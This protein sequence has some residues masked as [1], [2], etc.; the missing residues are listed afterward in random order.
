[1]DAELLVTGDEIVRGDVTDT[2]SGW[3]ASRLEQRGMRVRR[4]VAVGDRNDDIERTLLEAA[5]RAAVVVVGGGLGPTSDDLTAECAARV[6]GVGFEIHEPTLVRLRERWAVRGRPMPLQAERMARIPLGATVL[7]NDEGTAPGFRLTLGSATVFFF[8]GVPREFRHLAERHLLPFV[9]TVARP[10]PPLVRLRCVGIAESEVDVLLAPIADECGVRLGLRAAFPEVHATL[11]GAGRLDE[12]AR[13]ARES[14]GVRRYGEG[15]E[16]LA[17]VVGRAL[18][19]SQ[20]TVFLA[21]SCTGGLLG[22]ELTAVPGSSGYVLGGAVVYSNDE[23][24]R[25]L[26]VDRALIEAHGAVSEEV[27]RA[28]AE[29]AR[30]VSHATWGLSITGVAGPGGGT[31][32]KPVGTVWIALAGPDGTRAELL[33]SFRHDRD[34]IR[35]HSVSSALDLLRRTLVERSAA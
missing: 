17:T 31:P 13:R 9:E 5:S 4:I 8:A 30:K 11:S 25:A 1:M 18:L 28:M 12:A 24:V 10:P 19:A 7:D 16:T 20:E 34:S 15:D 26:G 29:G 22:G 3:L 6:A 14:L 2:N 23:K 35:V 21:E 33:R 32:T 27:A